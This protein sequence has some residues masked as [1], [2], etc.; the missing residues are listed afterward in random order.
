MTG[1]NPHY[2]GKNPL[3]VLFLV[4]LRDF[5]CFLN[6]ENAKYLK[7]IKYHKLSRLI[8]EFWFILV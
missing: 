7:F 6:P 3:N 4:C 1:E 8:V 5:F 2:R